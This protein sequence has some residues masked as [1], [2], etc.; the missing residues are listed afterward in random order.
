[1]L[2]ALT[3]SLL[4]LDCLDWTSSCTLSDQY[5]SNK[6]YYTKSMGKLLLHNNNIKNLEI[7]SSQFSREDKYPLKPHNHK[8]KLQEQ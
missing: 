5:K 1:M 8:I 3:S 6:F 4:H 7:E 2:K